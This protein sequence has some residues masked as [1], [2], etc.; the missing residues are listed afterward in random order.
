MVKRKDYETVRIDY[1]HYILI[2]HAR[3]EVVAVMGDGKWC[4]KTAKT[5]K[6]VANVRGYKFIVRGVK[7]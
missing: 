2:D 1:A 7:P 3:R 5:A 4:D 6:Y